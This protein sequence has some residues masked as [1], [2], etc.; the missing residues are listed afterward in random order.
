MDSAVE[1]QNDNTVI[2][3]LTSL[4]RPKRITLSALWF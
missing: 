1:P 3:S 2:F 4:D